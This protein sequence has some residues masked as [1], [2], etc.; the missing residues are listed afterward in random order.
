MTTAWAAGY[1]MREAKRARQELE[2]HE[3]MAQVCR[4]KVRNPAGAGLA[5]ET[6]ER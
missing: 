1:H 2:Y 3:Q 4:D 5:D 6:E